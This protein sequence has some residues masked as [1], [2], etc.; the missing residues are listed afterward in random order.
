MVDNNSVD[1][2]EDKIAGNTLKTE[3]CY[4][5]T[6][7]FINELL[8]LV[9]EAKDNEPLAMPPLYDSINVDALHQ[10]LEP[11]KGQTKRVTFRY[12]ECEITIN[13]GVKLVAC[14]KTED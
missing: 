14:L 4:T 5:D 7:T 8:C 2:E 3:L 11:E 1:K 13:S 6:G 9:A 12:C 10:F